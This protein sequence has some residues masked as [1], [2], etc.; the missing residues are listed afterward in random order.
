MVVAV[1][2]IGQT[3][4]GTVLIPWLVGDRI[5]MHPVAVI[6]S[7]MAGGQLFGFLGVLLALPV[8]AVVMVLLRYAHEQYKGSAMYGRPRQAAGTDGAMVATPV[9]LEPAPEAGVDAAPGPVVRP[10]V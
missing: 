10:D 2:A 6:F 1:F 8:A 7:I 3:L 5:G 4:E 9:V